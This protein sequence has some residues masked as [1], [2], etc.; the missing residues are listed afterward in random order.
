MKLH[1]PHGFEFKG[2]YCYPNLGQAMSYYY[3][4]SALQ[5]QRDTA[6]N[7]ILSMVTTGSGGFLQFSVL[8]DTPSEILEALRE[9]IAQREDLENPAVLRFAFAPIT[10]QDASLL[11]GDGNDTMQ[12]L[13]KTRSSG[14]LPYSTLFNL[15]LNP[16]QQAQVAAAL[17]GRKNFLKIQ[18]DITLETFA[19][20]TGNLHGDAT[21]FVVKL[22]GEQKNELFTITPGEVQRHLQEAIQQGQFQLTV[23]ADNAPDTLEERVRAQVLAEATTLLI[24]FFRNESAIA[25][26]SHW[27]VRVSL[28]EPISIDLLLETDVATWFKD[29]TGTGYITPAP[30]TNPNPLPD[31]LPGDPPDSSSSRKLNIHLDFPATEAPIGLIR[32]RRGN[33]Q[34]TLAPPDFPPAVLPASTDKILSI[35]TSYTTG[36]PVYENHPAIP[37]SGDIGLSPADLGLVQ[38][39]IDARAL[40]TAKAKKARIWLRYQPTEQGVADERTLHFRNAEWQANWF[41]ISRSESLAGILEYEWQVTTDNDKLVKHDRIQTTTSTIVLSL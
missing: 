15:Q 30:G 8:W 4:P 3:L 11:L 36:G 14:F 25:D 16:E 6:G 39:Q 31:E 29:G 37:T 12:E 13:Q 26:I 21:K 23:E 27:D 34:I 9:D 19:V 32:V 35:E 22:K 24:R 28:S 40:S 1:I 10:V 20:V 17:N 33:A 7:P 18:Y 2:L 5:P 38:V 41:L